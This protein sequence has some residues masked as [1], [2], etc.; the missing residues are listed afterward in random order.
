MRFRIRFILLL[1]LGFS[2]VACAPPPPVLQQILNQGQLVVVTR[3]SATTYYEGPQGPTG[4][5]YELVKRFADQLGV[6][7]KIVTTPDLN[8]LFRLLEQ[9]K[10]H[11]AAAGLTIT[12]ARKHQVRFGTP[13]QHIQEHLIYRYGIRRPR[14]PNDLQS[15][16][17]EVEA[18]SSHAERLRALKKQ[19]PKLIWEET[20]QMESEELLKLVWEQVVDFTIVNSNEFALNRPLYPELAIAFDVAKAQPLAWAFPR[21][22]DLSL[23]EAAEKFFA[24]LKHSGELERLLQDFYA[25]VQKFNYVDARTFK[26]HVHQRLPHFLADFQRAA[27]ETD[28]DWRLLAA[29]GYQES[30]WDPRAVSPTGV[31][32]IMMLTQ[33]TAR[34]MGVGDRKNPTES[35]DGGARYLTH[36]KDRLPERIAEPDRTWLALAAYNIGFAHLEDARVLTHR[37]GGD[38]DKW[39]DVKQR[40]P[41]LSKKRWYTQARYGYARGNAPVRYVENIRRYYRSLMQLTHNQ[42]EKLKPPPALF[43]D[44]PVL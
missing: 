24:E 36:L 3:N 22:D 4:L 17:L 43:I 30:H 31:R 5:E 26:S 1:I 20:D 33:A 40:L 8:R 38:P 12:E 14:T 23:Y 9:R 7:L 41:L 39:L 32:G 25:H 6:G 35:I 34:F 13:Y 42:E 11:L 10:V 18:G 2:L 29:I 16:Y 37:L 28:L 27:T 19:Y 15:G 44:P 21:Q